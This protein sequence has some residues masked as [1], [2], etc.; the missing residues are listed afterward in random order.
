[1]LIYNFFTNICF[2]LK[3]VWIFTSQ[4]GYY[5]LAHPFG[6]C[7]FPKYIVNIAHRFSKENILYVKLFQALSLENR[8]IPNVLLEFTDKAPYTK[9]DVDLES[10]T[11][12]NEQH[13]IKIQVE[14]AEPI[15]SGM[16]SLVYKGKDQDNRD[17]IIKIKRKGIDEK[18]EYGIQRVMFLLRALSYCSKT[19]QNLQI[20]NSIHK[21]IHMIVEQ[22]DFQK[23][24]EN[25]KRMAKNC[26][27]L[28]YIKIPKV[29]DE[30]T[31]SIPNIIVQEYLIGTP[32]SKVLESDYEMYA[33]LVLKYG[34]VTTFIHGFTHGDLHS[35]NLIFI[36]TAVTKKGLAVPHYKLG[37]VDFGIVL[38]IEDNV[39]ST[40]LN[41]A[42]QM[43]SKPPAYLAE[44]LFRCFI[45]DFDGLSLEQREKMIETTGEIIHS[46]LHD[47]KKSTNQYRV[48][49]LLWKLNETLSEKKR[50]GIELNDD[51][52]KMQMGLAMTHGLTMSLCK[53]GYVD[54]ANKVVNDLF[55]LDVLDYSL[56]YDDETCTM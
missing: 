35:G 54:Y 46:C 33:P 5:V 17:V 2:I 29:Y 18:L 21:N 31:H 42:T 38:E 6:V 15:N 30:I 8:W 52:V 36:K 39:K 51:F 20:V 55:H 13:K 56:D 22:L 1:M 32:F 3:L 34:F 25:T 14:N 47:T 10:I 40:F 53:D 28:S 44:K 27:H 26:K 23:E 19:I 4:T 24:V 16:I 45:N 37:L 7:D 12:L 50:N 9:D 43:Y 48:Y 11:Q 41:L 49:E